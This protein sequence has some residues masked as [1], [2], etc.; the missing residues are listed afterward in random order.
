MIQFILAAI[1]GAFIGNALSSDDKK[2]NTITDK[3]EDKI[4]E[5]IEPEKKESETTLDKD[6]F[7]NG[8][9]FNESF[10]VKFITLDGNE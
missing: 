9:M 10:K 6:N 4:K 7:E 5:I 1:G 3:V 2:K 8:G